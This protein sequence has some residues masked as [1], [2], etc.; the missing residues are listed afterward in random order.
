M[1]VWADTASGTLKAEFDVRSLDYALSQHPEHCREPDAYGKWVWSQWETDSGKPGYSIRLW[2]E[3]TD[4]IYL[5]IYCRGD[6]PGVKSVQFDWGQHRPAVAEDAFEVKQ[7][8]GT[9]HSS[10]HRVQVRYGNG[11]TQHE[12]WQLVSPESSSRNRSLPGAYVGDAGGYI[13]RY[14]QV[15]ALTVSTKTES[16][17][18]WADFDVRRLDKALAR[19]DKHCR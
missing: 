5:S 6:E 3:H 10:S 16:D 1:T 9:L 12:S 13:A 17:T 15:D 19:L 2:A 18:I 7:P 14:Q 8:D 4:D 11:V